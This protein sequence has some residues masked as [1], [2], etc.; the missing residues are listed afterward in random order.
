[1]SETEDILLRRTGFRAEIV[2]NRPGARNALNLAMW[3]ALPALLAPLADD[4][5]VRLVVLRGAG[6]H[7]AAGADIKEFAAA[8]AT[9]SAALENQTIMA[10]AM[11]ALADF[12]KPTLALLR[13]AC[14]GGGCA[15]AL[16]CDL[17]FAATDLR[18]GITPAKLG[19]AYSVADTRRLIAAVGASAAKR[20]LFTGQ[21]ID[22]TE[23]LRIGLVDATH[24]PD[25][26]DAAADAFEQQLRAAS[27]FTARA[28]KHVIRKIQAGAVADDGETRALFADAFEGADFREG[29][30][31]FL[32]KRPPD[33]P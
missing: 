4:P 33:F 12:P 8:Y 6:D 17:R 11:Q 28:V 27:G 24:A 31:A 15:L 10:A 7:F 2:L 19:L 30:S 16:C 1:M 26:L 13:G 20:I 23:A 9:R 3:S 18:I 21:L 14:V 25:T 5:Q 22:S 29:A 32:A